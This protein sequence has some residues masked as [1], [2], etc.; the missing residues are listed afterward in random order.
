[1]SSGK[2]KILIVFARSGGATSTRFGGFVKRI[3]QNGG[4]SYADVDYV[5]LESLLFHIADGAR[6]QVSDPESGIRL[7]SYSFV[8]FKSWQAMPEQA[9]AAA[10]YLEGM[11]IPY[12]DEQVRHEYIAKT[13]N[14]MAMWAQGVPV[15][16]TVWGSRSVMKR[17][18]KR[19]STQ[20]P[21][22]IKAVHGQKGN[23]NYL[24]HTAKEAVDVID[25]SERDMMIQ[26][27][28]PNDG[29]YRIG[30]YG[31]KARWAIYRKSGGTS[32]LNNTSAGGTAVYIDNKNVPAAIKTVAEAAAKACDLAISGVDVV[33]HKDTKQL[34]VFE[35]NQGSQI[36][37]GAFSD[38]N[39]KAF[40]AGIKSLV[41]HKPPRAKRQRK[42]VIGRR[43]D[44]SVRVGEGTIT[45]LAKVDTGAYQSAIDAIDVTLHSDK[46]GREYLAYTI[47]SHTPGQSDL[48]CTT[49]D[50][51]KAGIVS[52]LGVGEMRY[53]VPMDVTIHGKTYPA[54]VTL[55]NRSTQKCPM[56]LGRVLLAGNF[57]V[58]VE[59]S[60]IEESV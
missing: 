28:I 43:A 57:I 55:A 38:T 46:E 29:D 48:R 21:L 30:V 58:N 32:H 13:T 5:A 41:M 8:Y 14:Q 16:E 49:Y 15:P 6:A 47:K 31:H 20:Y 4:F 44:V 7:S 23:H 50:F 54:R 17:Y 1:M 42:S 9:A 27:F 36:V 25:T 40:D 2:P 59:Y 22:V 45:L 24:I 12:A 18:L 34:F 60:N 52:S 3:V 56:L 19:R 10:H 51:G 26:Q 35:A 33:E 53:V 39:M 37:T 11:G